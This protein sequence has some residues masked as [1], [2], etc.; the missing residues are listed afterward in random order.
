M[1]AS[2]MSVMFPLSLADS[3]S[4]LMGPFY[5]QGLTLI[6][7]WRSNYIH[8]DV[9]NAITY[10]LPNSNGAAVDVWGLISNFIPH[11]IGHVNAYS[12]WDQREYP[13]SGIALDS[14]PTNPHIFP[15]LKE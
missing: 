1:Y 13:I 6:P 14:L 3:I 4:Y 2:D 10:P 15:L 12:S 7:G 8:N 5:Q 11:F 9:W